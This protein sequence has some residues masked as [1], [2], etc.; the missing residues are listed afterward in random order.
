[1]GR[2]QQHTWTSQQVKFRPLCCTDSRFLQDFPV[3]LKQKLQNYQKISEKCL[4][5]TTRYQFVGYSY[6]F[7]PINYSSI[8]S[9]NSAYFFFF[10]VR[11]SSPCVHTNTHKHTGPRRNY[12]PYLRRKTQADTI[13][14][15]MKSYI[16]RNR[17]NIP[18]SFT[19]TFQRFQQ[20]WSNSS[21]Q[22]FV[23]D[24]PAIC[25]NEETFL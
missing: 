15:R 9:V 24:T 12:L 10:C 6:R 23:N 13:H 11:H 2:C 25:S 14:V 4:C 17:S 7:V 8:E 19:T 16:V 3:I 21:L 1:M 20:E 22:I 18:I 5:V